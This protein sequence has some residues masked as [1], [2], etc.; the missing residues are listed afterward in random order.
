VCTSLSF[1]ATTTQALQKYSQWKVTAYPGI[2]SLV[3]NRANPRFA[4]ST[5]NNGSYRWDAYFTNPLVANDNKYYYNISSGCNYSIA[6]KSWTDQIYSPYF[7]LIN[8]TD[9]GLPTNAS[10][11]Q[12]HGKYSPSNGTCM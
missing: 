2:T 6:L 9:G 12:D 7:A 8:P 5:P 1:K 11:P 10:C 4:A 3:P